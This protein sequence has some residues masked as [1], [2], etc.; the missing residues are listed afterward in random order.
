MRST[1]FS[2]VLLCT[3]WIAAQDL[4][5]RGAVGPLLSPPEPPRA[6]TIDDFLEISGSAEVRLAPTEA[7]L[8]A[9][10]ASSGSDIA[11]CTAD[12]GRRVD[13][14]RAALLALGVA[15]GDLHLDFLALEP[16][17]AWSLEEGAGSKAAFERQTGWRLRENLH[18]RVQRFDLLPAIRTA[19]LEAGASGWVAFDYDTPHLDDAKTEALRRA[20]AA[21]QAKAELLCGGV[22]GERRPAPLNVREL[23]QVHAPHALYRTLPAQESTA[24]GA[25]RYQ[26]RDLPQFAATR[27]PET[28]YHGFDRSV[29]R[30]GGTLPMHPEISVAATVWLYFRPP[31][32]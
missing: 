13:A 25:W 23:V 7:R 17:H 20:L 26:E 14:V 11:T 30:R 12:Q 22:F 27:D 18:V 32:R 19:A 1:A 24:A 3:T 29:D 8:V 16:T 5:S 10:I 21:A 15:P 31:E 28:Y 6:E 4:G 9:R 2:S